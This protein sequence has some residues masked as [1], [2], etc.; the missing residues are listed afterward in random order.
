MSNIYSMSFPEWCLEERIQALKDFGIHCTY[1]Y[2]KQYFEV[3]DRGMSS[4]EREA[5]DFLRDPVHPVKFHIFDY[6][7]GRK[8][9]IL[10]YKFW[11][12]RFN[13]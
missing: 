7:F 3:E 8:L 9:L 1:H 12:W 11:N 13:G 6:S 4:G 5:F 10:H 2:D